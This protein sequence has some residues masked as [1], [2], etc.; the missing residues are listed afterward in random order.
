MGG[1]PLCFLYVFT[2]FSFSFELFSILFIGREHELQKKLA[3]LVIKKFSKREV[4]KKVSIDE[5]G[6]DL[7]HLGSCLWNQRKSSHGIFSAKNMS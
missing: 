6:V 2:L 1:N 5:V 3:V 7:E 4:I